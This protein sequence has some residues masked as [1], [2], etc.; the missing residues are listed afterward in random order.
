MDCV[1]LKKKKWTMKTVQLKQHWQLQITSPWRKMEVEDSDW[2]K[3]SRA[4][5]R[6]LC[7]KM[8]PGSTKKREP[9]AANEGGEGKNGDL[10]GPA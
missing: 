7:L 3:L 10:K 6:D 5:K 1:W 2:G 8:T 4:L 9:S